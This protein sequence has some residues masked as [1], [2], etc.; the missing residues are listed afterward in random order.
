[1]ITNK[2]KFFLG[3]ILMIIFAVV[4]VGMFIPIYGGKNGLQYMDELYNSISKGSAYYI[5]KVAEEIKSLEGKTVDLVLTMASAEEADQSAKLLNASGALVNLNEA[6]IR[7]SGDLGKVMAACLADADAMYHNK[8]ELLEANYGYD[9]RLALFN[10]YQLCRVMEKTMS[11]ERMFEQSDEVM[12]VREKAVETAYNYFGIE[13]RKISTQAGIVIF[14]LFFY[15]V[16]TVWY[17]FGIMY[18][19]EGI[20]MQLEH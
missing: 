10:W 13:G 16:Y 6:E 20:G 18:L 12:K 11:R 17:G 14:S 5:P 1:M 2:K 4:L 19:F 7:L 15:V 9:A 8:G 3:S